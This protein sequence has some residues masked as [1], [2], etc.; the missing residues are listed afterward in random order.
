MSTVFIVE[1]NDWPGEEYIM[2]VFSSADKA[3]EFIFQQ[4]LRYDG[5]ESWCDPRE[6][7]VDP[8]PEQIPTAGL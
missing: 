2:G 3:S 8:V 6:Y 5:Q 1:S 7:E 4:P